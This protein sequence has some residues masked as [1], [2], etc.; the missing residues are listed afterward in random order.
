[1]VTLKRVVPGI[2]KG[3]ELRVDQ[4]CCSSVR[5]IE[6][7]LFLAVAENIRKVVTLGFYFETNFLGL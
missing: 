1:M 7:D 6:I 4:I 5:S 3:E 2:S